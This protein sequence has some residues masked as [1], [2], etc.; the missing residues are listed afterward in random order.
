[1]SSNDLSSIP[2]SSEQLAPKQVAELIGKTAMWLLRMRKE[3]GKGPPWRQIGGRVIY[4][5]SEVIE[6]FN[7]DCKRT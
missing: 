2:P 7:K 3:T 5:K 6:W 4:I 1:M